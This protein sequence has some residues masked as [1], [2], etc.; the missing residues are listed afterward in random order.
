[1][2]VF[3]NSEIAKEYNVSLTSVRRWINSALE[4]KNNLK[5]GVVNE[6][7]KILKTS[8]NKEI[9]ANLSEYGRI[10]IPDSV[11]SRV[12]VNDE[13]YKIFSES[14]QREILSN[15]SERKQIPL[16]FTYINGGAKIWSEIN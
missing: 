12:Q 15:L 9:L 16:K 8:Q 4:G 1:M 7:H 14:Q 3:N 11:P 13:F 5:I 10:Y 6:K 2:E